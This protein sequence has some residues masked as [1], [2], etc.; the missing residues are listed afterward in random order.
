M[1]T[2]YLELD[3]D[4]LWIAHV[5][6][7]TGDMAFGIGETADEAKYD[8]RRGVEILLASIA[9]EGRPAPPMRPEE[10]QFEVKDCD[11]YYWTQMFPGR[12]KLH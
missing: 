4:G 11:G 3:E 7:D 5:R 10:L 6:L 2:A 9:G 8:L 12:E 1:R